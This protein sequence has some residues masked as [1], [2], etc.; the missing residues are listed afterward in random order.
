MLDSPLD[1]LN[2]IPLSPTLGHR[3]TTT[4]SRRQEK[5]MLP[6]ISEMRKDITQNE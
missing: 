4:L 1:A 3:T 6:R 2:H 5:Y